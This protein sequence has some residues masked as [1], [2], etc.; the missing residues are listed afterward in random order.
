MFHQVLKVVESTERLLSLVK[1]QHSVVSRQFSKD[2]L[3]WKISQSTF[4]IQLVLDL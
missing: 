3:T 4:N 1:R 2:R